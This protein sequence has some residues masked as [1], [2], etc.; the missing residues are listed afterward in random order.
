MTI[1][2]PGLQLV[3]EECYSCSVLFGLPADFRKNRLSDK[4][5]WYCPNGHEQHYVGK[6]DAEKLKES[7]RLRASAE[8]E[9]ASWP[10]AS[11]RPP[12]KPSASADAPPLACARAVTGASSS[13][14]AT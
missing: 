3:V 14:R 2:T 13:W 6:T 10:P 12:A 5:D 9:A 7:E 8:E 4:R 11:P 1:P